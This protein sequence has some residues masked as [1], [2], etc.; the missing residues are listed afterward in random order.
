MQSGGSKK[1]DRILDKPAGLSDSLQEIARGIVKGTQGMW[2]PCQAFVIRRPRPMAATEAWLWQDAVKP[3]AGCCFSV[4]KPGLGE[5]LRGSTVFFHVS[6]SNVSKWG[7]GR[8]RW[9][10]HTTVPASRKC[11]DRSVAWK[12]GETFS[13]AL[14]PCFATFPKV[15]NKASLPLRFYDVLAGLETFIFLGFR[16]WR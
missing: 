6:E 1:N 3:A 5:Q 4:A 11:R 16:K 2:S 7:L 9:N 12:N 10:L 8:A 13:W 15:D 14:L